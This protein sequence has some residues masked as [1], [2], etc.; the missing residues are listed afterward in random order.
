MKGSEMT[1]ARY[2]ARKAVKVQWQAQGLKL[3]NIESS[4]LSQAA[5]A[6]LSQHR[7]ELIARA[8]ASLERFAQRAKP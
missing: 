7:E 4:K 2:Y 6:Y 5:N 3:Q 1:L 8:C